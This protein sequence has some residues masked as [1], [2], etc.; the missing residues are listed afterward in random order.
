MVMKQIFTG[1]WFPNIGG[2]NLHFRLRC[3]LQ[4]VVFCMLLII[5]AL[6][7]GQE[8]SGQKNISI[9][10]KVIDE[11]TKEAVP[12]ANVIIAGTTTGT[13][14]DL[15]GNF[16]ITVNDESAVLKISFLGYK[17][18]DIPVGNQTTIN[19]NLV[20]EVSSLDEVVVIGYGTIAK[21]NITTSVSKVNPNDV[22]KAANSSASQLLFG[23]ASGLQ[24]T[25]QSSEPGGNISL[26]IRGR[27]NPLIIVDGIAYPNDDLNPSSGV[28]SLNNVNRGG[29]ANINPDDIESMEVLKDASAAIYG[30]G[31]ANGVILVTTKKGKAG[32]IKVTYDGSRSIVKNMDYVEPLSPKEYMQYYNEFT[33]EAYWASKSMQPFGP[34]KQKN[35]TG[36]F[37]DSL[38]NNAGNGTDWLGK[39]LRT[40]IIDNHNININGGSDKVVYYVSGNYFNQKGTIVNSDLN[41]FMGKVDLTINLN[42]YLKLN[43]A[44]N[45]TRS[46]FTNGMSGYQQNGEGSQ[47]YSALQAAIAYP[48]YLPVRDAQGNYSIFQQIGNP[49]SLLDIIDKT[50]Q[51]ALFSKVALDFEIIPKMLT[52]KI[53]YGNNYETSVRTYFIPSTVYF[54]SMNKARGS[55]DNSQRQNQTFSG[56]VNFKKQ[57][58][59]IVNLDLMGGYEQNT[60]DYFNNGMTASGMLDGLEVNNMGSASARD[61]VSSSKGIDKK[62]S[63]FTRANLDILDRYLVSFVFRYDGIDKF[64]PK[65]KYASFPSVSIGWKMSK[66]SFLKDIQ[67]IDLIK[68]RASIGVTGDASNITNNAYGVY[69]AAS[70]NLAYFN[71]GSAVYVP[72]IATSTDL[73]NLNWQKTVNTNLGLDFGFF[74]NRVSGSF[75]YFYDKI[76]NLLANQYNSPLSVLPKS[77]GNDGQ[78]VRNGWEISLKTVN[79]ST[80]DFQWDMILNISHYLYRWEKRAANSNLQSYVGAKDPVNAIYVYPTN[81]IITIG[82]SIYPSQYTVGGGKVAK[83]GC[84]KFVDRDHNDTIDNKDVVMYNKD[85]NL[86]I[87][88]GNN[89]RYKG[90]DLTIFFYSQF[91]ARDFNNSYAWASSYYMGNLNPNGT[92]AAVKDS[93]SLLNPKG[94]LPGATYNESGLGLNTGTDVTVQKK[95]FVRCRNITLG[96]TYIPKNTMFFASLRVFADVQ[97][98][99]IITNYKIVDPEVQA[100][101]VKGGAAP[102]PMTR[103]Y[104]FGINLNF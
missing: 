11:S 98:P 101:A 77:Y 102:Y 16:K 76:S 88:L 73:P 65:N 70:D 64:F 1:I 55:I 6:L 60:S 24:T 22:P 54:Q 97:N 86:I 13:V 18:Q 74:K 80:K 99:F 20:Q 50:Q 19:V 68:L 34:F 15:N 49:V 42:K 2:S 58:F 37:S 41:R 32:K 31:A 30:I 38:I 62:R 69:S 7:N 27:G 35:P 9:T 71:N 85:P 28:I 14:T 79:I 47:G 26:S 8:A 91:G 52:G 3:L 56:Y 84:P 45:A 29:I 61:I 36:L 94:T 33:K 104:S 92:T 63:Y 17:V 78:Q 53:L 93:W 39:I 75:E 57:L 12:G 81:G 100:T 5:P 89:F 95:D 83:L 23:R 51:S 10:G 21:Q 87:G 4:T 40:G 96:Y 82:D 43:T 66:E 48:T 46:N 25:Q 103:T 44:F 90:F 72:Y 67:A 59:E